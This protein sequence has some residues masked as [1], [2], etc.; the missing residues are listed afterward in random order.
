MSDFPNKQKSDHIY[1]AV[2]AAVNLIPAVGGSAS[3]LLEMMFISPIEKRKEEWLMALAERVDRLSEQCAGISV[4]AL[5]Q[6][7]NF[8]S[9][10]IQA[11][12]IALRTHHKEKIEL[13]LSALEACAI[14]TNLDESKQQIFLRIIDE[15]TPLHIRILKFVK[16]INEHKASFNGTNPFIDGTRVWERINKDIDRHDPILDLI[17]SDLNRYGLLSVSELQSVSIDKV[18]TPLGDEFFSFVESK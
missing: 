18:I 16:N 14:E 2:K 1:Q 7:E 13:L 15:I 11:S 9:L 4:E 5:A 10:C 8:I 17:M 3:T 6:N 12:N